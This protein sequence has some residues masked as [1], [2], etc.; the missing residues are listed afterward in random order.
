MKNLINIICFLG[1]FFLGS[2]KSFA[3]DYEKSNSSVPNVLVTIKPLHSWV[4]AVMKGLGEPKLLIKGAESVHTYNLKPSDAEDISKA[5]IIFMVEDDMEVYL[6]RPL[7]NLA[8][9]ARVVE[10]ADSKGVRLL[11]PRHGGMFETHDHGHN[12]NYDSGYSR[13]RKNY[14]DD[15]HEDLH[16]WL[17]PE[18]AIA[19]T[20]KIAKVLGKIDPKHKST[21]QKN[22]RN[23]IQKLDDL[24]KDV[25]R[26]LKDHRSLNFIVFHD[27]YH[28]F[29]KRFRMHAVGSVTINP[30]LQPSAK[31]ISQIR[32][33]IKETRA[34]CVFSEPQFEPKLVKTLTEGTRARTGVLDPLGA[35]IPAG[36]D[37]YI[38]L[39]ENIAKSLIRCD[40]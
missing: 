10:L 38:I 23:Y 13:D 17:D 24:L 25:N 1:I 18:N 28:Y 9:R 34:M 20:Q 14:H 19:A 5:D 27:A 29:E 26:S 8:G 12:H 6:K 30:D 35:D 22:A 37:A 11:K 36:E 31:R 33:K 39:I 2:E 3:Q 40:S 21:Y 16:F 4:S 32:D 15:D 7:K